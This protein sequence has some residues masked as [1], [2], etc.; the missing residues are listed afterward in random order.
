MVG[1]IDVGIEELRQI[2]ID[3]WK[4]FHELVARNRLDD[5]DPFWSY[6]SD[7]D[8]AINDLGILRQRLIL[9]ESDR[10]APVR[11][12]EAPQPKPVFAAAGESP[13]STITPQSAL[14]EVM[15]IKQL[16]TYLRVS[17]S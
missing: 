6:D 9:E 1:Y 13:S 12:E 3:G 16:A 17:E 2:K 5:P 10:S 15:D 4:Q 8:K 7:L 14:P 11:R